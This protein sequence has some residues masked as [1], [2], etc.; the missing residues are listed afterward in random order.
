MR[1][2]LMDSTKYFTHTLSNAQQQ[3]FCVGGIR[4]QGNFIDC[5]RIPHRTGK[6]KSNMKE[7][8]TIQKNFCLS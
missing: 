5:Q 7:I 6:K 3:C 4:E 2:K 8:K 1:V